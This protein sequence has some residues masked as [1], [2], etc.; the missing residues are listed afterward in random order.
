MTAFVLFATC[1]LLLLL[2]LLLTAVHY[3]L[4]RADARLMPRRNRHE[5]LDFDIHV[6]PSCLSATND[7]L[8]MMEHEEV[9]GAVAGDRVETSEVEA[10][11]K[12]PKDELKTDIDNESENIANIHTSP[13]DETSQE[14]E[15]RASAVDSMSHQQSAMEEL[16]ASIVE[17]ET[18]NEAAEEETVSTVEDEVPEQPVEMT[19][20]EHEA[21]IVESEAPEPVIEEEPA[22]EGDDEAHAEH[23]AAS[24]MD[25]QAKV[26]S[27]DEDEAEE[28][29]SRRQSTASHSSHTT[30]ATQTSNRR[31]SHRT[32]AL[33]HAAARDIVAQLGT[34]KRESN[35][36]AT[37]TEDGLSYIAESAP[38]STR[39][40]YGGGESL[41]DDS[42]ISNDDGGDREATRDETGDSSSHHENEAEDDVFSDDSPRSSI[43]SMDEAEQTKIEQ[44]LSQRNITQRTHSPRISDIPQSDQDDD[45]IPKAW[46][47]PRHPFRSPSSVCA[48]QM[49]SPPPSILGTPRSS[50][51]TPLPTVSRLGSPSVSAQYSPKKTPPRFKRATPPL[52]LLHVTLLPLRWSGGHVLDCAHTDDLSTEAKSL[53][54]AWRQL[55]DRTGDTVSDRGILLP[56]PQ[57]DYEVLE[58]RLLEAL[59]LPL[60]RRAR[61]LE[62]GHY[63]GPA[64]Q[65]SLTEEME[66]EDDEYA[67]DTRSLR[68]SLDKTHWCRTCRSEIR[69]DSLGEGKVFRV[70]VYASNGLMRAGAW[71]ACWKEMERVDVELEPIVDAGLREEL[72]HLAL[73]QERA[74]E[75]QEAMEMQAAMAEDLADEEQEQEQ[76]VEEEDDFEHED[77]Y[78]ANVEAPERELQSSPVP[79][80]HVEPMLAYDDRRARDEERLREI[81][82][83]TPP[84]Q[85]ETVPEHPRQSDSFAARETPPSPSLEAFELRE[86]RRQAYKSASLPELVLEAAK[87][88]L[89]DKKNVMIGLLSILILMLAVRGGTP[90]HDPLAFQ[91]VVKGPEPTQVTASR[92]PVE[93]IAVTIEAVTATATIEPSTA[94][95]VME[96]IKAEARDPC[97]QRSSTVEA[98]E[99]SVSTQDVATSTSIST[100][101]VVETVTET[102]KETVVATETIPATMSAEAT[103][104]M[105]AEEL[106]TVEV[107]PEQH[108]EAAEAV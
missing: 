80:V 52:V 70:K 83:H 57:N 60:R 14:D 42:L 34:H 75:M 106:D 105:E 8:E 2:L 30:N 101:R 66:S 94:S 9:V 62:C 53:R 12:P 47:T 73:E 79:E 48:L 88:L 40:S 90:Q 31:T 29:N 49:S 77:S 78:V 15:Q 76:E 35:A 1:L 13:S 102:V 96:T 59:E 71:E 32:E 74:V 16:E 93:D 7:D 89:Q 81:Y 50:R 24:V 91:T 98:V 11:L 37:L 58:E 55:Q 46:G 104:M 23:D 51:R 92:E 22:Q 3:H 67:D 5:D 45:F 63:L 99:V 25:H 69:L 18:P 38:P 103:P 43:G 68:A 97:E 27:E 107:A 95:V 72:A 33:I 44:T 61:I 87:V 6:D 56:H 28:A 39:P 84:A 26:E 82:G 64:N 10:A 36:S 100:L 65:M 20:A 86:E 17:A 54:E 21:S 4:A 19:G 41:V 108:E 85:G